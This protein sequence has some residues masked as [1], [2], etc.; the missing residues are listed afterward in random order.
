MMIDITKGAAM[1]TNGRMELADGTV[2]QAWWATQSRPWCW[3][4]TVTKDGK[5]LHRGE[6]NAEDL[7]QAAAEAA[8]GVTDAP[9]TPQASA[10]LR[11]A[12]ARTAAILRVAPPEKDA[13]FVDPDP[14]DDTPLPIAQDHRSLGRLLAKAGRVPSLDHLLDAPQTPLRVAVDA[15][16]VDEA[17]GATFV[18]AVKAS[19]DAD[20]AP[21]P[22]GRKLAEAAKAKRREGGAEMR[23]ANC[24]TAF[25][26]LA[27]LREQVAKLTAEL[28]AAC[29][30][31]NRE[32]ADAQ[33]ARNEAFSL[34][35]E[36][37]S[38]TALVHARTVNLNAMRTERDEL[39]AKLARVRAALAGVDVAEI[40]AD[41]G[42]DSEWDD[43]LSA[44]IAARKA[45]E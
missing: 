8:A 26:S 11:E 9:Q 23:C 14:L 20:A 17:I 22:F 44:I 25:D 19:V 13:G 10:A 43:V 2:L 38:Q 3:M 7:A 21:T 45:A 40:R 32:A 33:H 12:S 15:D 4:W 37:G 28:D 5:E 18:R 29:Q 39:Q 16:A 24:G 1:W 41:V 30:Q 35:T 36:L 27:A 42:I 34:R 6:A 31:R